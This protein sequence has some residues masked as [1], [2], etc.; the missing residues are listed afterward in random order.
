LT[1]GIF[2]KLRYFSCTIF[3]KRKYSK[4]K[5][6]NISENNIISVEAAKV[7]QVEY[8]KIRGR[9]VTILEGKEKRRKLGGEKKKKTENPRIVSSGHFKS[10]KEGTGG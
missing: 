5:I 10:R 3:Y 8:F 6:F 7:V 9:L 2:G 4:Q 1:N